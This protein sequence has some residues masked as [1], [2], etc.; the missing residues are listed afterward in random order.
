LQTALDGKQDVGS[1]LTAET[2]DLS[3]AVVWVN[4]PDANITETAVTQ[5]QAALAIT[6]SQI[7][8]LGNYTTASE[9]LIRTNTDVF[10]PSADYHPATKKY[11]DDAVGASYTD[12]QAQDAVGNI[13]VDSSQIN[14]T[15]DDGT[16]SITAVIVPA[17]I[18]VTA[19]DSVVNASLGLADSATQPGDNITTLANNAGYITGNQTVTL[20][21]DVSGSGTTAIT[22]TLSNTAVTPGSYG[23]AGS[24]ATFTVDGKGRLTAAGNTAIA[25]TESQISDLRSYVLNSEIDADLKTLSVPANTTISAFGASL[26]DDVNAATARTTLGVDAAGT[27]N[28][29]PVTLAGSL[30]Y[31]TI[32]GQQI[33]R[34]AIDLAT[35][36]TGNLPVARLNSGTGASASTF[37]R[38]DGTWATAGLTYFTESQSTTSPNNTINISGLAVVASSSSAHAAIIPKGS[39]GGITTSIADNTATGGNPIGESAISLVTGR[40]SATQGATG[41]RSVALGFR[42]TASG[43]YSVV[44]GN[45]SSGT[46]TDTV[47][48]G[49]NSTASGGAAVVVGSNS[50]A[51]GTRSFCGGS[52]A[53][54]SGEQSIAIGRGASASDQS[55]IAIG[56]DS[57]SNGA[58]SLVILQGR[59]FG[60][61][62]VVVY[63]PSNE[64]TAGDS[65]ILQTVHRNRTTD[66]TPT[67]L[68]SD[69]ATTASAA[70]ILILQ[71]YSIQSVRV[72]LTAIQQSTSTVGEWEFEIVVARGVNA[73]STVVKNVDI[74]E[75]H[76]DF[77]GIVPSAS[78]VVANTTLGGAAIQVTGLAA[79]NIQWVAGISIVENKY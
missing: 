15:Y 51:S 33:T 75:R 25:I 9:V 7:S 52:L 32:S 44:V 11:V 20:S 31:I 72:K 64:T 18:G 54:A 67:L 2:N 30:D 38:G 39:L 29:T 62:G 78:W 19:L 66:A 68:T 26:I 3:A 16:P 58:N 22:A 74:I 42:A 17:S 70:N 57:D 77:A 43:I 23:A 8:D 14:F 63:A 21:G 24:V 65:Q 76:N 53:T 71:N 5:H 41:M 61:A 59:A 6:E 55:A 36:I 40:N 4:V 27:D 50:V 1:Y 13:L 37:W 47:V 69:S 34:N 12:E 49:A 60:R 10:S 73:A 79:T 48:L 35:D 45:T 56:F 46:N 28:S